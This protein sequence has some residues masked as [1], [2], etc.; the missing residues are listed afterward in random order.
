VQSFF[1]RANGFLVGR[2]GKLLIVAQPDTLFSCGQ[3][4]EAMHRA[5]SHGKRA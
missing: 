3:E 1:T 2:A 4:A 5:E